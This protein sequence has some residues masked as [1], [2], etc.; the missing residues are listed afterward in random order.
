[1][2]TNGTRYYYRIEIITTGPDF[3]VIPPPPRSAT[4]DGYNNAYGHRH[5]DPNHHQYNHANSGTGQLAHTDSNQHADPITD[6]N[7]NANTDH[8]PDQ[9]A[10]PDALPDTHAY[11]HT[12]RLPNL[13]IPL[14]HTIPIEPSSPPARQPVERPEHKQPAAAAMPTPAAM[15][16]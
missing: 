14:A 5:A 12:G 7:H 15:K 4:A 11:A 1:M 9:N 16:P 13:G 6:A 8:Y 2:L 10:H 3:P